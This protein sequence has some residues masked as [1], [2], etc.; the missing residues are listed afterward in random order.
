[1]QKKAQ[2][3]TWALGLGAWQF[4]TFTWQTATL[5]SALSGFTSEFGM[6]SGGSRS[7]WSPSNSVY[8]LKFV[9]P[10]WFG[11]TPFLASLSFAP[12][13][14]TRSLTLCAFVSFQVFGLPR[15]STV[16]FP[17]PRPPAL[18]NPVPLSSLALRCQL[19]W[20]PP[21]LPK[22]IGCYK[23]KPHG[24]LVHVSYTHYC[25]STPCLSTS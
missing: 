1:M 25:A 9:V 15:F 11:F 19:P 21:V 3:L 4:P 8:R 17:A 2:G 6:G 13:C 7:L 16:R 12:A 24:Q 14:A 23:V 10:P 5:S 20:L 18:W 22:L